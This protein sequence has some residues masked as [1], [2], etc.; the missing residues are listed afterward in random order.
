[1][2]TAA[3]WTSALRGR[4]LVLDGPDGSGKSTQFRRLA[5]HCRAAGVVVAETREPGGTPI[6]EQI[7]TVLLDPHNG[8]MHVRC[9]TMLYMASRAQLVHERIAPALARGELV[10]AD[11]FISSTL[12]YQGTAGG[13]TREE[14]LAVGDVAIGDVR[15]HLVILFDVDTQTA[16]RR[17]SLF[18]DRMEQKDAAFHRRVR[19]GYLDQARRDPAHHLVIDARP[20]PDAVWSA[21]LAAL[22]AWARAGAGAASVRT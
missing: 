22:E 20:E 16:A 17:I 18:P 3:H 13:L 6:G 10:L 19:E 7:R 2:P 5:D 21:L 12:A 4:F 11:R 14:I 8:E 9:E 1:M 15:P